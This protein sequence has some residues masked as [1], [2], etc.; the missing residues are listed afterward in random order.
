M[1][2]IDDSTG[3]TIILIIGVIAGALTV[4]I[5]FMDDI[6]RYHDIKGGKIVKV[7]EV[8]TSYSA[9]RRYTK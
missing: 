1:S 8:F 4:G 5:T 6:N 2:A 7:N 9:V 3:F